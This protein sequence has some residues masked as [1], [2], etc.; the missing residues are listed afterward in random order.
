[1]TYIYANKEVDGIAGIYIEPR[2]FKDLEYGATLVY[3]SDTAIKNAYEAK[4]V[5]VVTLTKAGNL[6][7]TAEATTQEE[8]A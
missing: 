3:T 7:K 5:E 6:K 1:M 4:E 8:Q 2:L